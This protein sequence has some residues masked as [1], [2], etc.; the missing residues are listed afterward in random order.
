MATDDDDIPSRTVSATGRAEP[1]A[2]AIDLERGDAFGRY[3][4]LDRLGAGGMGVVYVAYDPRARPQ[5]RGQDLATG[6]RDASRRGCCARRRP[7][8][9]SRI[10]TSSPSTT[11][12]RST[13]GSSSPW[14][15]S[16]AR[17]SPAGSTRRA[18]L[19][20]RSS[21]RSCRP[22]AASPRR[23]RSGWSIATSSRQTCSSAA[24]G[25]CASST[26]ASRASTDDDEP[27]GAPAEANAALVL[28]VVAGKDH[29]HAVRPR[30]NAA[31]YVARAAPRPARRRAQRSVQL[32]RRALPR[33]LRRAPFRRRRHGGDRG[34]GGGRPAAAAAEIDAACRRGS[35]RSCC[36]AWPRA[37]TRAGRRWTRCWRRSSA[38]PIASAA[39]GS[40]P[41]AP[42]RC[43]RR[44]RSRIRSRAATRSSAAAPNASSPA[45]GTSRAS[46][47]C[48]P[49]SPR[50]DGR[51]PRA[52]SP[53]SPARSTAGAM[54]SRPRTPKRARRR[55]CATSCR[56]SCS[57]CAWSASASG[58]R[59]PRRRSTSSRTPT[60]R[61]S[62]NRCAWCHRWR[63]SVAAAT[64]R[65]CAR[66]C[67]R[68][69]IRRRERASKRC[70]AGSRKQRRSTRRANTK[71]GS[72]SPS[73]PSPLRARSTI[74]RWKPRRCCSSGG[75]K[76]S[77]PI[78]AM[79]K[80]RSKTPRSRLAPAATRSPRSKSSAH[81]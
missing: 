5:G 17:R 77:P 13:I 18:R 45:S 81:W 74:G 34:R 9:A 12:A 60:P 48:T 2:S 41:A 28:V 67:D 29:A 69:P 56:T 16:T 33:A 36:A 46:R 23:T 24:T 1:S 49:P 79:R 75:C 19:A 57:I 8:R 10:P 70:G 61:W 7:W 14:S 72:R 52:P 66:R 4:V 59:R 25:A 20:R 64:W 53:A 35:R 30:R 39:A 63:A 40:W 76:S 27:A 11:S 32:Q 71:R 6:R 43:W 15:S 73:P 50:P 3:I 21:T 80:R 62:S 47:A 65:R 55:A 38:I 31:L 51:S 58:C 68:P 78:R 26:S 37:P 22:A 42:P 44:S 54:P